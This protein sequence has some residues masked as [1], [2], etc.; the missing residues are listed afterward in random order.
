MIIMRIILEVND[1]NIGEIAEN[2]YTYAFV[3]TSIL[4]FH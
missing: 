1:D 2:T 3:E 4:R